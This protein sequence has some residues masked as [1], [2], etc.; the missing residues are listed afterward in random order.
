[1][2]WIFGRRLRTFSGFLAAAMI[3]ALGA[4]IVLSIPVLRHR[5]Q[6]STVEQDRGSGRVDIWYVAWK[7]SQRHP[8][9]GLGGGNFKSHSIELLEREPG[10][11]LVKS[12]LLLLPEG[13][14]VHNVYL[15]T[16]AEYGIPGGLLFLTVLM[17]T[18]ANL[19]RRP[20]RG[21]DRSRVVEDV[22][23][24]IASALTGMLLAFASAAVFL[25]IVNNKL[26]WAL[27]GIAAARHAQRRIPAIQSVPSLQAR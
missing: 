18:A 13:I 8:V 25:S 20:P 10:V 2:L 19:R 27:V 12:H 14:E 24:A 9:L 6:P 17:T 3:V 1:V 16:L 4:G 26:L 21:R 23:P 22:P 15:E 5:V 11:Q 7:S